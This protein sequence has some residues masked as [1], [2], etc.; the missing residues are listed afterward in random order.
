MTP[1]ESPVLFSVDLRECR[2]L[3]GLTPEALSAAFA[4]ALKR[5]GAN[6]VEASSHVFPGAGLTSVL[7]LAESHAV[8][9]TWPETGTVN[10]DIFSCTTRLRSLDAVDELSKLLG[11]GSVSVRTLARA[12]GHQVDPPSASD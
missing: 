2:A 9:H 7:I 5:A 8:I 12:D 11:A 4:A 6:V 1:H 3:R 10:I